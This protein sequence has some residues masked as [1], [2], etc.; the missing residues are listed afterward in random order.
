MLGLFPIL[1]VR[2]VKCL[3]DLENNPA[4]LELDFVSTAS[5]LEKTQNRV[6]RATGRPARGR[7]TAAKAQSPIAHR[8]VSATHD[9]PAAEKRMCIVYMCMHYQ[10]SP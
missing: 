10:I 2:G 5:F 7:K 6:R 3:D 4:Q 1:S 9:L 8:L